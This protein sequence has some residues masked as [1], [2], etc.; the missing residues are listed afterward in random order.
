MICS[1]PSPPP[2]SSLLRRADDNV[3][4]VSHGQHVPTPTTAA[5]WRGNTAM[6][7]VALWP[8]PIKDNRRLQCQVFRLM[9]G[10]REDV[11]EVM[12]QNS[13]G[14]PGD[15]QHHIGR[16]WTHCNGFSPLASS[17]CPMYLLS[18]QELRLRTRLR[19]NNY[20]VI[21]EHCT[22]ATQSIN[23]NQLSVKLKTC[24]MVR[25]LKP[26]AISVI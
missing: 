25:Q 15:D 4:A 11:Q 23:L 8:W 2:R 5:A 16:G 1:R 13:P 3:V 26:L 9:T 6:S 10:E 17:C 20:N 21:R 14:S 24:V 12:A 22:S 7:K 19:M 18:Q